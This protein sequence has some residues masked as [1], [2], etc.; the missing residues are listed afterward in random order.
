MT[1]KQSRRRFLG[2]A[3]GMTAFAA[4][5]VPAVSASG[6]SHEIQFTETFEYSS[7]DWYIDSDLPSTMDAGNGWDISLTSTDSGKQVEY[8]LDA[9]QG[10]GLIWIETPI[11]I[12]PNTKYFGEVSFDVW[13]PYESDIDLSTLRAYISD[14]KP[15]SAEDF[16]TSRESWFLHNEVGGLEEP[17]N[18]EAG[19]NTYK[20]G[21][22]SPKFDSD[23]VYLAV[24]VA[25]EWETE[26]QHL[27]DSVSV[28]LSSR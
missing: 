9:T 20:F 7:R 26:I 6:D 2:T 19:W 14:E 22:E 28:S 5:G 23:T 3:A 16:P 8:T 18:K 13:S 11:D 24:G 17:L 4:A 1:P 27:L 21:W 25:S 10:H 15:E 12:E